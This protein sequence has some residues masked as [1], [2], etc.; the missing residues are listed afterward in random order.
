M[1]VRTTKFMPCAHFFSTGRPAA[2]VM[3][4]LLQVT[5]IGWIPAARWVA[6]TSVREQ[7][8]KRV[9]QMLK[10]RAAYPSADDLRSSQ[11]DRSDDLGQ[12]VSGGPHAAAT[13]SATGQWSGREKEILELK[14]AAHRVLLSSL[15]AKTGDVGEDLA[16]LRSEILNGGLAAAVQVQYPETAWAFFDEMEHVLLL[17]DAALQRLGSRSA[18]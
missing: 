12:P 16:G 10:E 3:C 4:L 14:I 2:G 15:L 5:V 7:A 9:D 1:K 8:L 17:S 18:N 13:T 11:P 6:R